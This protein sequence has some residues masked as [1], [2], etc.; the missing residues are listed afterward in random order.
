MFIKA[1]LACQAVCGA[2]LHVGRGLKSSINPTAQA[3][4]KLG[5]G[6]YLKAA[7]QA[8]VSTTARLAHYVAKSLSASLTAVA[9]YQAKL[10]RRRPQW[11]SGTQSAVANVAGKLTQVRSVRLSA[12]LSPT[13]QTTGTLSRLTQKFMSG[14]LTASATV[15][16]KIYRG[17]RLSAVLTAL[18]TTSAVL[19]ESSRS[20]A[21]SNRIVYIPKEDRTVKVPKGS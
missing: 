2:V 16:G 1:V 17:V 3:V 18:C 21:S 13:A 5:A 19:N 10:T 12:S 20:R 6:R 7:L 15:T 9:S 11:L 8:Q 4:S 14:S